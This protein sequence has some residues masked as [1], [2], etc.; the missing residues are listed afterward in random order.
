MRHH[1]K[2]R[3]FNRESGQR[4]ALM[5]TLVGSLILREKI[6]TTEAKAKSLRPIIEKMV[7]RAK[8]DSVANRRLLAERLGGPARLKKLFEVI[9]PR[10]AKRAGGY[11]RIIKLAPRLGDGSKMAII[12]FVQE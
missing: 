2:T 7:T 11:T 9:G 8:V 4:L 6:K 10:Y 12:E 5:R 1:D 3:K